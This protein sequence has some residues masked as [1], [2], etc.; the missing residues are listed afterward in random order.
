MKILHICT[1]WPLS[2]SGGITNYVRTI[3]EEQNKN[4]IDTYVLGAP[5][6]RNYSFNYI[7]YTS[8]RIKPFTFSKLEDKDSLKKI[9]KLLKKEQFDIIHIHAIEY[10]DWDLYS[11]VKDYK[12]VVSLHDYCFICPRVYMY[13]NGTACERYDPQRC[14]SCI[15]YLDRIAVIRKTLNFINR[16]LGTNFKPLHIKQN[17]TSIRYEKFVNQLLNHAD[18]VLPVSSKVEE[19]FKNSGVTSKSK[20]LHIG[21]KTSDEYK[22]N[23][24]YFDDNHPVKIVFLGRLSEYKGA[25]LFLKIA[26]RYKNKD[27]IEFHFLGRASGY[28]QALIDNGIVN[29]GPYNPN[30]L[31]TKLEGYDMGMVLSVWHDNGP[32]VVMELL[33]NHVPVIGTKMGGITDFVNFENGYIFNPY[34]EEEL[35]GLYDFLDNVTTSTILALKKN[36]K[37]T[38]SSSEHYRD[39]LDVYNEVISTN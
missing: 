13:T 29:M 25:D 5:D 18:Y 30:E 10:V 20:V 27:N 3:A 15:S 12:Y 1:G 2:F 31:S 24:I 34:S 33:N 17:I 19:I 28:E 26:S 4:G 14:S 38:T 22:E 36:I 32:Q 21:N 39:L 8:N 9:Q 6:D 16:K 7:S 23:F 35:N 37:R 11:I